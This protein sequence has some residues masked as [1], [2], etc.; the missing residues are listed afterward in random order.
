MSRPSTNPASGRTSYSW[1]VRPGTPVRWPAIRTSPARST[2]ASASDTVGLDRP[3]MRAR[4]ARE[5]GPDSRM[6]PRSNC[7]F[8]ARMSGGRAADSSVVTVA[9]RYMTVTAMSLRTFGLV[10]LLS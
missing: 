8:M 7:S 9:S 10:R 3:E 6:W 5:P 2:F 1:A 4:S